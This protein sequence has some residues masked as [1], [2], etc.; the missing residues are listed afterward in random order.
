MAAS[1]YSHWQVQLRLYWTAVR[2]HA[3][4]YSVVLVLLPTQRS[5]IIHPTLD[6]DQW[7]VECCLLTEGVD[8]VLMYCSYR[9]NSNKSKVTWNILHLPQS[10]A[11]LWRHE[12]LG[13]SDWPLSTMG[14]K[15]AQTSAFRTDGTHG[16][17]IQE[18][19]QSGSEPTRHHT[20]TPPPQSAASP[21]PLIHSPSGRLIM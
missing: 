15:L 4:P 9:S 10:S 2:D 6:I 18:Q 12:A 11:A 16:L 20:P 21:G 1:R 14:T 5:W 7:R 17:W 19:A 3:A 8:V 13:W